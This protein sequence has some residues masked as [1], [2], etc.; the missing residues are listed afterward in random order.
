MALDARELLTSSEPFELKIH[1]LEP[2]TLVPIGDRYVVEELQ[3]DEAV[4]FGNLLVVTQGEPKPSDDPRNP[5]S[6][7]QVERR[8]VMPAV[9]VSVGDGHLLGLPDPA[10]AVRHFNDAET[11]ERVPANVPMFLTPGDVVL[12]DVNNRGRALRIAG[13]TLRAVNQIDCLIKLNVRL[14]RQDSRWVREEDAQA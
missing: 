7:P 4:K 10:V 5:M 12:V 6:N 9:V 13:R 11:V 3:V 2:E 14:K 8:G 1:E